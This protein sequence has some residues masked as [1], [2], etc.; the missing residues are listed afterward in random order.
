MP[1]KAPDAGSSLGVRLAVRLAWTSSTGASI[2]VMAVCGRRV[3][4][5]VAPVMA[6]RVI[7]SPPGGGH[8]DVIDRSLSALLVI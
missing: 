8:P 4:V 1:S 6:A 5:R 7:I 2:A 3:T